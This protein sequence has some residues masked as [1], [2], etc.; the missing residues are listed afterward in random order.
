[1]AGSIQILLCS[2][3]TI[4]GKCTAIDTSSNSAYISRVTYKIHTNTH[5]Q[6]KHYDPSSK[7][8]YLLCHP[9]AHPLISRTTATAYKSRCRQ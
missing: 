2:L 3:N 9:L 8:A 6:T 7:Y 1:M 4:T 5:C